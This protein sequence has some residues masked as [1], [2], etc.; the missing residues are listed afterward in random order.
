L[1]FMLNDSLLFSRIHPSYL[2]GHAWIPAVLLCATRVVHRPTIASA[3]ALAVVTAFQLLT[4]HPQIVCYTAYAVL[5]GALGFIAAQR[6]PDLRRLLTVA[7]CLGLAGLVALLVV[8][9]QLLPTLE[10]MGHA[11]RGP[12]TLAETLPGAPAWSSAVLVAVSSGPAIILA[13][14]AVADRSRRALVVPA[15]VVLVLCLLLGFGTPLYTRG[16][17]HLPGV[18]RFRVVSRTILVADAIAAVLAGIGVDVLRATTRR[19]IARRLTL[20][21]CMLVV[22]FGW[23][24]L[25]SPGR[26]ASLMLALI[27]ALP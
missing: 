23:I 9:V 17:F 10:L 14:A 3:L 27:V 4:G 7:G 26:T 1:L 13:F 18:A 2:A 22:A 16:F 5:A 6:P 25:A 24:R 19:S 11:A 12:L 21:V 15:V 8:A 20:A